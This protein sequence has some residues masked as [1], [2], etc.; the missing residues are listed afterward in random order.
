MKKSIIF[1]FL[2]FFGYNVVAQKNVTTFGIQLKPMIVSKFFDSGA[3]EIVGDTYNANLT[4]RLGFNFGMLMRKGFTKSL[5]LEVAINMVRRNYRLVAY[6]ER[7]D[8]TSTMD[9]AFVGYE[10]PIQGLL[11]V[12]LGDNLYM[13]AS[14]GFSLDNYPSGIYSVVSN[15]IDTLYYDLEQESRRLSWIQMAV[16][17]N[18]GFEYRT[19][20]SGYIYLGTSLH[21]S[22]NDI[23]DTRIT[24][25][26]NNVAETTTTTLGG[27]YVTIDLRYFFHEDPERQKPKK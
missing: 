6:D 22:F 27:S 8:L 4:P 19:K 15:Q 17:A 10:L 20:S 16:V 21:R 18:I 26:L 7:Y 3:E 24:Y 5:S 25:S 2:F 11:Y 1:S 13:N 12:R 14:G 9:F 23:A